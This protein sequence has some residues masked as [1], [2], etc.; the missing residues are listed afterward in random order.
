MI[1]FPSLRYLNN[2]ALAAVKR[3]PLALISGILAASAGNLL[4]ESE[5]WVDNAFPYI[6]LMLTAAL[7]IS[8][9]FCISII[10]EKKQV[11]EPYSYINHLL[12]I[13][14]MVLVY[15][16]LPDGTHSKSTAMPYYRFAI[17]GACIHLMVSFTP[18][19]Q[20]IHTLAFWNYNK[21]LFLRFL[22]SLLYSL[23]L[24]AGLAMALAALHL[25]FEL[26][27]DPKIYLQLFVL[28]MG[29]F[30][31]WVFLAGIPRP[32]HQIDQEVNYPKGLKIF[33]QYILLSLLMVYLLILYGYS[34]K[35]ILE[36]DW[37]KGIVAYL[38]I[39]MAIWGILTILLL[40]P[41]R[42]ND[43][44]PWIGNFSRIYFFL[45]FPLVVVLFIAI[46]IR[47]DD[48][49]I[50]IN[51]Y[52]IVLLGAWL[53][54]TCF[55]FKLGFKS[56]KF[57]P[58]SLACILLFSSFGPWG[59]FSVS[60][61][62]Q[63]RRLKAILRNHHLLE[64]EHAAHEVI[65]DQSHLPKLKPAQ[66]NTGPVLVKEE[67]VKEIYSITRY[68][69]QHHSLD[70]MRD[71]YEQD[72]DSILQAINEGKPK[73]NKTST[74]SLYLETL[75]IPENPLGHFNKMITLQAQSRT[76]QATNTQ[77]YDYLTPIRINNQDTT[78]F[79][80][81]YSSFNIHLNPRKNG[82][83]I[84]NALHRTDINLSNLA[85][86][87]QPDLDSL[88]ERFPYPTTAMTYT[89]DKEGLKVKLE[90]KSIRF[91][92]NNDT[93]ITLD[94]LDGNLLLRDSIPQRK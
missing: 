87:H 41:Y 21:T 14:I 11:S 62:S 78:T 70:R 60:E 20:N 65:W 9:F 40:Y 32:L 49:G 86:S 39:G 38:I 34:L 33:S 47:I 5:N 2:Q 52:L 35:I 94:Y 43:K 53:T 3:F 7:G 18:Y 93:S 89:T 24:F 56:I 77:G 26:D 51:K 91:I 84:S 71:W 45:L 85:L 80:A 67:E 15:F 73:W 54:V 19:L 83:S 88:P 4:I 12:G 48:Y 36:W 66:A 69:E 79:K 22:T 1:N 30:N 61:R 76:N 25:L 58:L 59:I 29:V 72:I 46:G 6:N 74:A 28:I 63:Y 68:L 17:L 92:N 16:S 50:T 81:G 44:E 75:G 31:T 55:Y 42:D 8:C 64:E 23:V 37:P 13:G 90:L 57:I 82:I 27:I 10:N